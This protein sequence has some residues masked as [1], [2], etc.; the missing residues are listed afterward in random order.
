MYTLQRYRKVAF[1]IACGLLAV[2]S[3][4]VLLPF[5]QA[6]AWGAALSIIAYPVRARLAKRMSDTWAAA[7]TTLLTLLFIVGPV[8][9]VMF[10][11]WVEVKHALEHLRDISAHGSAQEGAAQTLDEINSAVQV[12]LQRFGITEFNLR[13]S[14]QDMVDPAIKSA[15]ALL[16]RIVKNAL[17]FIFSLLLLFFILRDGHKLQK[18]AAD[19][20]PL[21]EAQSQ[22][23]LDSVY[24]TV[25]AT[26]YGIVLIAILNGILIGLL[27]FLLGLPSPILWGIIAV[28]IS[29]MPLVG[30][31][32]LY[33]PW[34]IYLAMQGEW[35]K[36]VVLTLVGFIVITIIIDKVYRSRLIGGRSNLHE[37]VVLFSMVGGVLALGAVGTFLGPVIVIVALGAVEVVREMAVVE[38]TA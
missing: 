10:A 7:V 5:W 18:P 20:I 22:K 3:F 1:G 26:F 2:A 23:V 15:P 24:D 34:A 33:G 36:A 31:P 35:A 21:P 6:V 27:F 14:I 38:E 11:G 17:I 30:A 12:P 19:L 8:V 32:T 16:G 29:I 37:V 25:H 4:Y 28:V 9:L 13:E